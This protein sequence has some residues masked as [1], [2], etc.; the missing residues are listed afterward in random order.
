[1]DMLQLLPHSKKDAKLDTKGDRGLINEVADMKGCS[2]ALFFETRKKKDLYLWIAKTP[3]GP[4]F[5]FHVANGMVGGEC[6]CVGHGHP[7]H[8]A[9]TITTTIQCTPWRS[10]SSVAIT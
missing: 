5:K 6:W 4:T 3:Q 8:I 7:Q 2:S 9:L 1:M 10:S